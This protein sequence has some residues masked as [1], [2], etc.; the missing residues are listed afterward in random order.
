MRSV[1]SDCCVTMSY[2]WAMIMKFA[3]RN[4]IF[5]WIIMN[6]FILYFNKLYSSIKFLKFQ[7]KWKKKL[8][9]EFD[10]ITKI[11]KIT[12]RKSHAVTIVIGNNRQKLLLNYLVKFHFCDCSSSCSKTCQWLSIPSIKHVVHVCCGV[13]ALPAIVAWYLMFFGTRGRVCVPVS[14]LVH[15][16][17]GDL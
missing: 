7:L 12:K 14:R 8:R 2:V 3:P 1:R 11:R 6:I 10:N 4:K 15:E 9:K 13:D 5:F 17:Y 16:F